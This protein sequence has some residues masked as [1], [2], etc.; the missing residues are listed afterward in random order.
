MN[1]T[2]PYFDK[3][4]AFFKDFFERGLSFEDYVQTG[5]AQQRQRWQ[6]F[7]ALMHLSSGQRE[8]LA[9]FSRSMNILVMSGIWCGDC[10]RQG[11]MLAIIEKACPAAQVRFIESKQSPDLQAELRINGAEKVP[12]VV[13]LSED[14]FEISRFGDR[15]LSVYRHKVATE[16]GPACDSGLGRP[17]EQAIAVELQ[18]WIDHI[19]RAQHL[20]RLAPMLR[21]RYSD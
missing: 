19:E 5:S 18:E 4:S 7:H 16:L 17:N 2:S 9:S 20:L 15:H 14:F 10:A 1:A 13:I 21:K 3:R 8:L 12:V 11:P 6:D